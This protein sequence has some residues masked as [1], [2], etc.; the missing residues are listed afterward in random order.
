MREDATG[1]HP[2]SGCSS[3]EAPLW[4]PGPPESP[5]PPHL[6]AQERSHISQAWGPRLG[7]Q[8]VASGSQ[9]PCLQ[10]LKAGLPAASCNGGSGAGPSGVDWGLCI[11]SLVTVKRVDRSVAGRCRRHSQASLQVA[12]SVLSGD[13]RAIQEQHVAWGARSPSVAG[14]PRG[15]PTLRSDRES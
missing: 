7:G 9:Q 1:K 10:A 15:R 11:L 14:V 2:G 5:P 4:G 6:P 13:P 8:E 3:Q 12:S